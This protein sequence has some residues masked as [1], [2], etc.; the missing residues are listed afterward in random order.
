MCV[1]VLY[2]HRLEK[3]SFSAADN[4]RDNSSADSGAEPASEFACCSAS[5]ASSDLFRQMAKYHNQ[6]HCVRDIITKRYKTL[7]LT[8][9]VG[10][11]FDDKAARKLAI[12]TLLEIVCANQSNK[13][14]IKCL[15]HSID[16]DV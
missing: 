13:I 14:C 2:R 10:G 16:G 4:F 3:A 15:I 7:L 11:P 9:S 6:L 8:Y 1:R 5:G 12:S